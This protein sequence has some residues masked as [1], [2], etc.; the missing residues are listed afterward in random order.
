MSEDA[1]LLRRYATENSEAA[2]AEL[3]RRHVDLVYS[4]ALRLVKTYGFADGHSEIQN[5]PPEGLDAFE[6]AHTFPPPDQ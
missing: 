5:E 3:I 1:E 6:Q 2:F 4:A